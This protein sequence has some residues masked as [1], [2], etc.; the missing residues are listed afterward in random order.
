[1]IVLF[2]VFVR[3]DMDADPHWVEEKAIKNLTTDLEN[4]FYYRYPSKSCHLAGPLCGPRIPAEGPASPLGGAA[5]ANAAHTP[6][7]APL[8]SPLWRPP[9][10]WRLSSGNGQAC[11]S[12]SEPL[13]TQK[14]APS[15]C[16]RRPPTSLQRALLDVFR[17]PQWV[18][19]ALSYSCAQTLRL[20]RRVPTSRA[21]AVA[22]WPTRPAGVEDHSTAL[23]WLGEERNTPE[24]PGSRGAVINSMAGESPHL[25]CINQVGDL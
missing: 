10:A 20:N 3:Y 1:M 2:G 25:T 8:G 19:L 9:S 7:P 18:T 23:F 22:H 5:G 24:F 13:K 16:P 6:C 14:R 21:A 15:R 11:P 4:E 17:R 12:S